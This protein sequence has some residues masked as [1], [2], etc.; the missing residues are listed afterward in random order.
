MAQQSFFKGMALAATVAAA[1]QQDTVAGIPWWVIILIV[2]LVLIGVVIWVMYY[3]GQKAGHAEVTQ[4]DVPAV[5][6]APVAVPVSIS[7][8][9][10]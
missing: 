7:M 6:T 2:L 5:R 4:P 3:Q 8:V 9:N 10:L 1:P